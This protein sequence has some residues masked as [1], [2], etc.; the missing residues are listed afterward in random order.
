MV[1]DDHVWRGC[2]GIQPFI[3]RRLDELVLRQVLDLATLFASGLGTLKIKLIQK[4]RG[5]D[6]SLEYKSRWMFYAAEQSNGVGA[7]AELG[8]C[9]SCDRIPLVSI[10]PC[11]LGM[12]CG[13]DNHTYGSSCLA[14]CQGMEVAHMRS[15]DNIEGERS[16]SATRH[17]ERIPTAEW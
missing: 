5:H 9:S 7:D 13:I 4:R 16:W 8:S 10:S 14:L 6:G 17:V 2:A 12:V 11:S 15:C 3:K 1:E